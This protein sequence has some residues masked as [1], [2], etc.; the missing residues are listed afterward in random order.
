M[1]N[2]ETCIFS[3]IEN[4]N[5][6]KQWG[7]GRG[8]AKAEFRGTQA[9]QKKWKDIGQQDRSEDRNVITVMFRKDMKCVFYGKIWEKEQNV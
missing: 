7:N 5:N 3:T 1:V 2:M 9:Y 8:Q 6:K 4:W